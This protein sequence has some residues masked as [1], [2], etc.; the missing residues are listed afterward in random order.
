L[1]DTV[2]SLQGQRWYKLAATEGETYEVDGSGMSGSFSFY[3]SCGE[4]SFT[5]GSNKIIFTAT[6][7]QYYY[8]N[9]DGYN[10]SNRWVASRVTDNRLCGYAEAVA[11]GDTVTTLG[12]W[13]ARWYKLSATE[14]ETYEVDG[15]EMNGYF[16]VYPSCGDYSSADG[17]GKFTL[18]APATQDYYISVLGYDESNRW[19]VSRV[20]DN[21][22]CSNAVSIVLGDTV[23]SLQGERW[24]K[25]A[26]T[27]GGIY[28]V[29]KIGKNVSVNAYLS[30]NGDEVFL[31]NELFT[32]SATRDYYFRAFGDN[33]TNR[34]V[35]RQITDNRVCAYADSVALGDTITTSGAQ[36]QDR[37]Y[38]LAATA[39]ET[40]EVDGSGISASFTI[41]LSC[42]SNPIASFSGKSTLA[43]TATQSYYIKA[44]SYDNTGGRWVVTQITDNRACTYATPIAAG[45]TVRTPPGTRYYK[46]PLAAGKT[47]EVDG[48]GLSGHSYVYSSCG[49]AQV[50]SGTGIFTFGVTAAQDYYVRANNTFSD[51]ARLV[52]AQITDNRTCAYAVAVAVGDTVTADEGRYRW[53]KLA[54]A[55]GEI[56]GLTGASGNFEVYASCGGYEIPVSSGVFTAPATQNYYIRVYGYN[57]TNRWVVTRII[58]NS[59]CSNAIAVAAGDTVTSL[60]DEDR[61]YKLE[62]TAGESYELPGDGDGRNASI[63][64]YSSCGGSQVFPSNGIFTFSATQ[65]YYLLAQGNERW[66]VKQV[67]DN[68]VCS[69]AIAITSGDTV[70]SPQNEYRWHK[71]AVTVGESYEITGIEGEGEKDKGGSLNVYSSCGGFSI[72]SGSGTFTASATQHYY[73]RTYSNSR[74]VVKQIIDNRVCTHAD[75]I[76]P[77]DTVVAQQGIRWYKLSAAADGSYVIDGS[78]I[79]GSFIVYP[80]CGGSYVVNGSG[81]ITFTASA[82]QDY[83]IQADIFHLNGDDQWSI[84]Q[85]NDNRVCAYADT[86]AL[87]DTVFATQLSENRWYQLAVTEGT[88]YKVDVSG[89]N[90]YVYV[91]SSCDGAQIASGSGP[92]TFTFT[93]TATQNYYIRSNSYNINNKWIVT[94]APADNLTCAYADSITLGDTVFT[95]TGEYRWYKLAATEGAS[96]EVNGIDG[97]SSSVYSSCGG[98]Q[99]FPN[100][101]IFTFSATQDY[102]IRVRGYSATNRWVIK[103]VTDNRVCAYADA[104]NSGDTVTTAAQYSYRWYKLAVTAGKSY[105]IDASEMSGNFY[106]YSSCGGSTID[107]TYS[108]NVYT[109][110]APVTRD[111]YIRVYGNNASNRWIIA[112]ITDNRVCA[113]ADT[114]KSGDTVTTAAQ[115]SYRWYKLAATAG[116]SYEVNASAMSGYIEVYSSCGGTQIAS[117][118]GKFIFATPATQNY[119]LHVYGHDVTNS[120]SIAQVT[121][122]RLCTYAE[123]VAPG[124]NVTTT[125]QN[126]ER[127]Y[128]LAATA[129]V[130]YEVDASTM[131]GNIEVYS[132]C[133]GDQV[134]YGS[135]KFT[136]TAPATQH[137]YL[138]VYG[139]SATNSWS[140]ATISDNRI[141]TGA[142]AITLGA[143]VTT[144]QNEDRWYKLAATV[145]ESYA[146]DGDGI[147]GTFYVY[148][149]CGGSAT[150]SGSGI[151]AFTAAATQDYYILAHGNDAVNRWSV[152]RIADAN[153]NRICANAT[154]VA[155]NTKVPVA[156]TGKWY[157]TNVQAGKLYGVSVASPNG[158]VEV[159]A[160]CGGS[161]IASGSGTVF[162]PSA[163][164][165]TVSIRHANRYS[166]GETDTLVVREVA[167]TDVPNTTC[168]TARSIT[169]GQPVVLTPVI[170]SGY[171]KILTGYYKLAVEA[172]K[173]YEIPRNTSD[174]YYTSFEVR[175]G[176][177]GA[178]ITYGYLQNGFAFTAEATGEYIIEVSSSTN[179]FSSSVSWQVNEISAPISCMAAEA[180]SLDDTVHTTGTASGAY[181]WY[182]L[183]PTSGKTYKITSTS[184]YGVALYDECGGA[185]VGSAYDDS[186]VFTAS[187]GSDCYVRWQ[188]PFVGA[189]YEFDWIVSEFTPAAAPNASCATA[190]LLS[191]GSTVSAMLT[192]DQERWYKLKVTAGKHY[193]ISKS[194]ENMSAAVYASCSQAPVVS[195]EGQ[196][197]SPTLLYRAETDTAYIRITGSGNKSFSVSETDSGKICEIA[198][199]ITVGETVLSEETYTNSWYSIAAEPGYTYTASNTFSGSYSVTAYDSC[200]GAQLGYANGSPLT[201]S[202][203]SAKTCYISY[204]NGSSGPQEWSVSR[205]EVEDNTICSTAEPAQLNTATTTAVEAGKTYW[206]VFYGEAGKFYE[207]GNCGGASFD[208]E[209]RY[210]VSC[211]DLSHKDGGC[212][213]YMQERI[214]VAGEGKPVYFGWKAYSN[215]TS[216]NVTWT[217]SEI[218]VGN[219]LCTYAESVGKGDT[220]LSTISYG[221]SRWYQF[222]AQAGKTYEIVGVGSNTGGAATFAVLS[223]TCDSFEELADDDEA[224]LLFQPEQT[225]SYYIVCKDISNVPSDYVYS[226]QVREM[227]EN[228]ICA[229]ATPVAENTQVG[230]THT[231]GNPR[232]YT[233]TA[234]EA[235]QYDITA[236]SGQTLK[237]W[238]GCESSAPIATGSG[239]LDFAAAA[240]A[241]YYIEWVAAASYEYSYSWSISRHVPAAL[242]A[243]S[244]R[245]YQLVPTFAPQTTEYRVNVPNSVSSITIDASAPSGA[246]ITGT[247]VQPVEVGAD[248]F[249]VT[250]TAD[251]GNKNYKIIVRRA[252]VEA[253]SDA[254]LSAL[255]VSAGSLTPAFSSGVSSYTVSVGS[256]VSSIAIGATATD[257]NASVN[258]AGE[259]PLNVGSGN[260]FQVTVVAEDG[261]QGVYSIAVT[262]AAPVAVEEPEVL[263]VTV[264]PS[265]VT[266]EPGTRQFTAS[267][268]V[269]GGAAQTVAWSV[270]GKSSSATIISANG[271][272]VVSADE[273]ADTLTVVAT[274]TVNPT[275]QGTARVTVIKPTP[276]VFSV[277]VAP[278]PVSV[279]VGATQQFIPTVSVA[280]GASQ[281]VTW[282]VAGKNSASTTI[283]A[284][285]LLTVAANETAA[286]LTVTATS[287]FNNMRTGTATVTVTTEAVA[288]TVSSVTVLPATSTVQKGATQQLTATV[289]VTGGAAQT[290]AWS[291]AGNTSAST[292]ISA[293]GLLTV[294]ADETAASLTVRA[295][296][297]VN[298]TKFGTATVSVTDQAA[299]EVQSV[300]V[301]P[302]TASVAKG[303]TQLFTAAVSATG[304]GVEAVAWSVA[305]NTSASTAI[306]A[307]GLLT[308]ADNETAATLTVTATSLVDPTKSGTAT[309]TITATVVDDPAT[310]VESQLTAAAKLY[311]NPFADVLHLS[312]AEGCTLRVI[313]SAGATVYTRKLSS[314]DEAIHLE[315]LPAGSYFIHLEKGGKSKTLQA[316]KQ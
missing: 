109:F 65:H 156:N 35:V 285:G 222:T 153:D 166:V 119:Y 92:E 42:G 55:A 10:E 239:S 170:E 147:N 175:A 31:D 253:S 96:Y 265:A 98:S 304:S 207:I 71:L 198:T 85:V 203:S 303:A 112:Q 276:E 178:Y 141:C 235:G 218:A 295:T 27:E 262:R 271:L 294:A 213:G 309:V 113:Y 80:S 44:Y 64:V 122:N 193:L 236:P 257:A 155:L 230:N 26:A 189:P 36:S 32:A 181:L 76:T 140:I 81:K 138:R 234:T 137:Y 195:D 134:A 227:T 11:P 248:T 125:G 278:N 67:T 280:G 83:Y 241:T 2:E 164:N 176:C 68:R 8:I 300:A 167:A 199:P 142:E 275:M 261:T 54:A 172:G 1:G 136:L 183:T 312:G 114:V 179:S 180:V 288:P 223:G 117:G 106:V 224:P 127:W 220:I 88:S 111:Y 211:E 283:S 254:T 144:P 145:G 196:N 62:A 204:Y 39:G 78:A 228:K 214:V 105:A 188:A 72:L 192:A 243:L 110:T 268:A 131:S 279:Q 306:S 100:S 297:T 314:P 316:V 133:G 267:V 25:L 182:K 173:S 187:S 17:N 107:I 77:G 250:V 242:T 7:S 73:L 123:T 37:W 102:Y 158:S 9:A 38:K 97:G 206:Y 185:Q 60:Q 274:S 29:D 186:L 94:E 130:S 202:V 256:E 34:W 163:G 313:S 22:L 165:G 232:W 89:M 289:V 128:K 58:D 20:T 33:E 84:A 120:W 49:G 301:S 152:S 151:F 270:A 215:S 249:T 292:A 149:A 191:L 229:N 255:T 315:S 244:V 48:S 177:S 150:T 19:V 252:A 258:G 40:Y 46:L 118:S 286:T 296:S 219:R 245:N 41:Y 69:N 143:T 61:W 154:A 247:G 146:A 75:A 14:G 135:G 291:V 66:A 129:D 124:E 13:Q 63:S 251:D 169:K 95:P 168:A 287:T 263:T 43:A 216:G 171:Y 12:A 5:D 115:Y 284:A 184:S 273:T 52:V 45:D 162:F 51:T 237:V 59:V 91:H 104:V 53:Y 307:A 299:P 74:W 93:A 201:F 282:S 23:E 101:E 90:I 226:W 99:V 205:E 210:G 87:G 132:S 197:Y 50:A 15:S 70:T 30:C 266:M 293:A 259:Y 281:E 190:A 160:G 233:F 16:Q 305:G 221:I 238:T 194:S 3:L 298:N 6:A 240:N 208:T 246:T 277:S 21:R 264:S 18:V 308:V 103:Q 212:N 225:A 272:L 200:G 28:G 116:E 157:R 139:Y 260:N 269:A 126:T 159:Y 57:E 302:A 217:V 310:G 209:L 4:G 24:Y 47:Y 161:S 121:D 148:S 231:S 56:Y 311:P 174:P 108:N 79:F 82:T 290:V 86:I